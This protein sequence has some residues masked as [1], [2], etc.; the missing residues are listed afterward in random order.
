MGEFM[1]PDLC[2]EA[3]EV[4]DPQHASQIIAALKK[5]H[6]LSLR[7]TDNVVV[8]GNF[9]P[10]AAFLRCTIGDDKRRVCIEIF[11]RNVVGEGL[12]GALGVVVDYLDGVIAAYFESGRNGRFPADFRASHFNEHVV[13]LRGMI[14]WPSA[15]KAANR[16]LQE[17]GDTHL[18]TDE[19]ML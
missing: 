5:K 18:I 19:D 9:G 15:I 6:R 2:S 8:T 17:T 10:D 7:T 16:L 3:N 11:V 14:Q 13:Y 1:A 4:L 12:D